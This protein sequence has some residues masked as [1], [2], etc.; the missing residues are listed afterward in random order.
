M[1][2]PVG[3]RLPNA[4]GLHDMLGNVAE[5]CLDGYDPDIASKASP[6]DPICDPKSRPTRVHRGGSCINGAAM[7]RSAARFH[8]PPNQPELGVGVRPA[9]AIH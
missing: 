2:G 4:F 8:A 6:R 1:P 5:W 9:R 3:K 7:T